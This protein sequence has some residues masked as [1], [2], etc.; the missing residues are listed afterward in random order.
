M[1]TINHL[2]A[3]DSSR[4]SFPEAFQE[5]GV[6]H[7]V[8]HSWIR[9]AQAGDTQAYAAIVDRY[10]PRVQRW[11]SGL[12]HDTQA[13]EDLTQ[14][15]F[16]K[17][18]NGLPRFTAGSNFRA[19]LFC[20]AR[21]C[22]IDSHRCGRSPDASHLPE[23]I[24]GQATSPISTLIARETLVLVQQAVGRLPEQIREAFL[25]RTQEELSYAEIGQ[26]LEVNEE[27]VRWRVFK[28]RQTLLEELGD[29]LDPEA[30]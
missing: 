10:W 25:L 17:A 19:W 16:L 22:L 8:E 12:T 7:E 13:A 21:R 5:A 24:P 6:S 29:A 27:T 9:A 1:A 2:R 14:E 4:A 18:W 26:I 30:P 11:L 15:V 3:N 28:A 20:I 23:G